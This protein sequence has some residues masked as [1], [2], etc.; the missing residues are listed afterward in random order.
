MAKQTFEEKLQELESILDKLEND[1]DI[2]LDESLALYEKGV[3]LIKD[4]TRTIEDAQE[5]IKSIS[6]KEE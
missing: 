5:K 6:G 3:K 1:K 2:S 4:C